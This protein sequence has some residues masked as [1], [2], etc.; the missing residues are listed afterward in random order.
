MHSLLRKLA[1]AHASP[2][3]TQAIASW[4][5]HVDKTGTRRSTVSESED[6]ERVLALPRR[7]PLELAARGAPLGLSEA[8]LVHLMGERLRRKRQDPCACERLGT[9]CVLELLG[10]QAWA[11]YEAQAVAG[12]CAPIG[13]GHGKTFLDILLAMVV[14]GCKLAVLLVPP[15]LRVQLQREYLRL[16]EHWQVPSIRM[17][18]WGHIVPGRPVLHVVP[19]SIFSRAESTRLLDGLQPDLIIADEAHKLRNRDSARTRRFLRYFADHPGTRACLYS[20]TLLAKGIG[21]VAH[22]A[23]VSLKGGSP[24]PL[25]PDV[26]D[27]WAAA[28][29]PVDGAPASPGALK[30]F[31]E[32]GSLYRGFHRR[33]VETP[34]VVATRAGA[35]GASI[36]LR[37]ASCPAGRRA[38]GLEPLEVPR[39]LLRMM[40]EFRDPHGGKFWTRPDGEEI[41]DAL[42]AKRVLRQLAAGFYHRW[43]YPRGEPVELIDKWFDAR[44]AFN[45]EMRVVLQRAQP[46][47]DSPMLCV[48][49]AARA[50]AGYEGELPTWHSLA[51]PEWRDVKDLVKPETEVVWIDEYLARDAAAWALRERGIVWYDQTAFGR[52][53]AELAG[54]PLHGGGP[55]AEA[56]ILAERGDRS[57]VASLKAHGTGRDGL[58]YLF[59]KNLF[60]NPPSSAD[61]W[62][63]PMGRTHRIGQPADEVDFEVYR[64]TPELRDAVDRAVRQAKFVEGVMGT[65]QKLLAATCDFDLD[66]D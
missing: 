2:D 43:R 29:D 48:Q 57:V 39:Q 51:W 17:G 20:G 19:Y 30:V 27:R 11:L 6:L 40:A 18:E 22:L 12:L 15:E 38:R 28:V 56:R 47:L 62:E 50:C 7:A 14:P 25:D 23:A 33:I 10:A 53:V 64:H 31:V 34:G 61:G 65:Y 42:E 59:C 8:G 52:R 41:T 13:V 63:Q 58:Q 5:A 37:D 1:P 54:L 3:Q 21:D 49:A 46:H 9:S 32:D 45:R 26:V 16:R 66:N 35:I 60:S 4:H 24:L 36:N 44:Q 55:D